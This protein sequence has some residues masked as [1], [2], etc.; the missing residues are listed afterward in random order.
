[1]TSLTRRQPPH[2]LSQRLT[3]RGP[4]DLNTCVSAA[5]DVAARPALITG[6]IQQRT[7]PT[8]KAV[9]ETFGR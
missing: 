9:A 8:E 6:A 2:N 4:I 5:V 1:M 3:R 7:M